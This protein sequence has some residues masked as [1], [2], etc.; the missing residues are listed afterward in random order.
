MEG[1][2]TTIISSVCLLI[3]TV[4]TVVVTNSKL[5]RELELKQ[6]FQQSEIDELKQSIKEHNNYAKS[7]PVIETEIEFIKSMMENNKK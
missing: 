5:K 3:G 2:V 6:Q 7:I 4:I 1:I